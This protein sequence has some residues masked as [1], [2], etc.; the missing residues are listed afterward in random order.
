MTVS[1]TTNWGLELPVIGI[2][3]LIIIA[4]FSEAEHWSTTRQRETKREITCHKDSFSFTQTVTVSA[5][6]RQLLLLFNKCHLNT[7][8]VYI[9]SLHRC[10]VFNFGNVGICFIKRWTDMVCRRQFFCLAAFTSVQFQIPQS[11]S[12]PSL[13]LTHRR[14]KVEKKPIRIWQIRY[15]S[16]RWKNCLCNH[17]KHS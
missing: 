8:A 13:L 14:I 2:W 11:E 5:R 3:Q 1:S 12:L 10:S 6:T 7:K 15:L 16:L 4:I 9:H 17:N